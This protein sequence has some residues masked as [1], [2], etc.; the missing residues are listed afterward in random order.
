M[1]VLAAGR[2]EDYLL[3]LDP[4]AKRWVGKGADSLVLRLLDTGNARV[5]SSILAQSVAL[6]HYKQ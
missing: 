3:V 2:M 5:V 6:D 1:T 4:D